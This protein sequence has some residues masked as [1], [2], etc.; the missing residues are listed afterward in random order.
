MNYTACPNSGTNSTMPVQQLRIYDIIVDLL[1]GLTLT[2]LLIPLLPITL[3]IIGNSQI[4]LGAGLILLLLAYVLGRFLHTI[5]AHSWIEDLRGYWDR[6][7][8]WMR[9]SYP[10]DPAE[11]ISFE[12]RIAAAFSDG[13]DELEKQVRRAVVRQ[14]EHRFGVVSIETELDEEGSEDKWTHDLQYLKYLNQSLL[15]DKPALYHTYVILVTFFRSIWLV[16]VLSALFYPA[17]FLLGHF[18]MWSSLWYGL[19]PFAKNSVFYW[20][21]G[22]GTGLGFLILSFFANN[23]RIEFKHRRVRAMI[24]DIYLRLNEDAPT[25][26]AS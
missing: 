8:L 1:P 10:N 18:A 20:V 14:A 21:T 2:V 3:D 11:D 15:A 25:Q 19:I 13:G 16:M 4:G 12:G 22:L 24:N 26:V 17:I 6:M 5:A 23:R 9:T 7:I